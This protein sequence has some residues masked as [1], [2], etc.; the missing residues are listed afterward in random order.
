MIRPMLNVRPISN[1]YTEW[2]EIGLN[3]HKTKLKKNFFCTNCIISQSKACKKF[4]N[5]NKFSMVIFIAISEHL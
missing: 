5:P 2:S 1:H 4:V 3:D